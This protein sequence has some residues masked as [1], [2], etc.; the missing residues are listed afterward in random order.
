MIK[1]LLLKWWWRFSIGTVHLWKSVL[2]AKYNFKLIGSLSSFWKSVVS[3][4]P[5]IH[6]SLKHLVGS[7]DSILFWFDVWY[8]E[9]SF[10]ILFPNLWVTTVT[11]VWN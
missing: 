10:Y 7:G 4:V 5:T 1:A 8:G 6:I 9:I 3:L 2:I 11:R